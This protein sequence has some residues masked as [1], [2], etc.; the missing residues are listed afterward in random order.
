MPL[1]ALVCLLHWHIPWITTAIAIP[2]DA[3]WFR[4]FDAGGERQGGIGSTSTATVESVTKPSIFDELLSDLDCAGVRQ[5][6]ECPKQATGCSKPADAVCVP[7]ETR[8]F[9]D[10]PQVRWIPP[11][12]LLPPRPL[13]SE[14]QRCYRVTYEMG[15]RG[16]MPEGRLAHVC[17][18]CLGM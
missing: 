17:Q 8:Q 12:H 2:S 11:L 9:G 15:P 16:V 3:R 10:R 14:S 13:P 6:P 18:G 7:A 4:G 5:L 1:A